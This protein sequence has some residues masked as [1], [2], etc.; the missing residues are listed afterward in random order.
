MAGGVAD[1]ALSPVAVDLFCGAGGLAYGMRQAGVGIAAGI[2][3]DPACEYPFEA[4]VA[5]PF[6]ER[7]VAGMSP[8]DLASLYPDGCVRVLAGCAPCQPFSSYTRTNDG[9]PQEWR[10]LPGFAELAAKVRPEIVTMEN[11]PRLRKHPVFREFLGILGDAGYHCVSQRVVHCAEYGV[12]Q[13]RRRLVLLASLFGEIELIPPER[14]EN[15]FATVRETI[16]R[17][18]GIPAGG[19]SASDPLHKASR[20]SDRNMER[21]RQSAPGGTWRDWDDILRAACHARKTGKTYPGVYGRMAWDRPGPTITTQFHGYGTG[22]FGHP[23]QDRA[24]SLREGAMLQTF[25][26]DYRFVP[27]GKPVRFKA[28]ARM[29]GNA[30]PVRLGEAIGRSIARHLE[31]LGND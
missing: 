21:I 24:L 3:I 1:S 10:L 2:D 14:E 16:G 6:H 8:D 23:E 11:V 7:D 5:A 12:P 18:D 29:I 31:D 19:S 4:N 20:L 9:D 27:D 28:I 17:L 25:P 22:R 13:T 26:E 15:Q 30:V